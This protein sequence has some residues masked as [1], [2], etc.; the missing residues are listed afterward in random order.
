MKAVILVGGFGTRLKP[1]TTNC[2]KSVVPF[3]GRPMVEWQI[4]SLAKFG[5]KV[6]ILAI[7]YKESVIRDF[8]EEMKQKYK[9]DIICS[10][11]PV[12]LN[13]GG[14]IKLTEKLLLTNDQPKTSTKSINN[15]FFVLNSDII[16]DYPFDDLLTF[17]LSHTGQITILTHPVEDPSRYG[18]IVTEENSSK[19]KKFIEK[20]QTFVGDQINAGIYVF[21]ESALENMPSGSFSL[22]REFFPKLADEGNIF[23][24]KLSGFWKDIG[25][26]SDFLACTEIYLDHFKKIGRFEIDDYKLVENT[27]NYVGLNLVHK[28][29]IIGENACI[30]PYSVIHKKVSIGKNSRVSKSIVMNGTQIDDNSQIFD[31]ILMYDIKIGKWTRIDQGSVIAENVEIGDEVL[32][33]SQK[34]E[35]GMKIK[36]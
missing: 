28:E 17:H 21:S 11:E 27:K 23:V 6:I 10:V 29:A 32:I 35:P 2:P 34:V 24:K 30:G 14:P 1:L 31:S 7:F 16:C 9:I 12:P 26:P 13:T 22:E 8:V 36:A 33:H 18:V 3:A 5:V 25:I 15:T 19:V 20:P 4:E